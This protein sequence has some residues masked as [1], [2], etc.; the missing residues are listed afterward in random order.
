MA[1][2]KMLPSP[3]MAQGSN[4]HDWH[5]AGNGAVGMMLAWHLQRAGE[6]VCL[7]TRS[8]Q[9][10]PVELIHRFKDQPSESWSCRTSFQPGHDT[11]INRLVVATKSFSVSDVLKTWGGVLTSEARIYF[12]Q[13]GRGFHLEEQPVPGQRVIHVV[14]SGL[15]GFRDGE[16]EVIQTALHPMHCGDALGSG[17]P[18][19]GQVTDDLDRLLAAGITLEW[20]PDIDDRR[21]IKVAV[22]AAVNPLTVIFQCPNGALFEHPEAIELMRAMHREIAGI[23]KGMGMTS[24]AEDLSNLTSAVITDTR[25]NRSSMLQDFKRGATRNELDHITVPLIEQAARLGVDSSVIQEVDRRARAC[26][27]SRSAGGSGS[28]G[29]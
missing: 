24:T 8:E 22:N 29:C 19:D 6:K 11:Q 5:I 9:P 13:N 4:A 18:A 7:L 26:F 12:M 10:D 20:V 21:W 25:D 17:T 15:A 16:H 28:A 23:F 27:A 1:G 2:V 3:V 14:N